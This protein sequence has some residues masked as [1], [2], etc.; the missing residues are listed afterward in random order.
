M[1]A[2]LVGVGE[3]TVLKNGDGVR[4]EFDQLA[5]AIL[6]GAEFGFGPPLFGDVASND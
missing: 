4:S 2:C 5:I 1:R 6:G 3:T